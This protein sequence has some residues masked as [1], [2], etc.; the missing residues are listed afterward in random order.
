MLRKGIF[1]LCKSQGNRDDNGEGDNTS[2]YSIC[3]VPNSPAQSALIG[4]AD[5]CCVTAASILFRSFRRI[6]GIISHLTSALYLPIACTLLASAFFVC[7]FPTS[8]SLQYILILFS[9]P[10]NSIAHHVAEFQRSGP[11]GSHRACAV[12]QARREAPWLHTL[13]IK[14]CPRTRVNRDTPT[15]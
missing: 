15:T 4:A 14:A 8:G 12:S 9:T 1:I 10:G 7:N 11:E 3:T 6:I 13:T 5:P 2:A